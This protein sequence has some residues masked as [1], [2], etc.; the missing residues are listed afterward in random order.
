MIRKKKFRE[1][2]R[3]LGLTLRLN[4]KLD[5][6]N[7]IITTTNPSFSASFLIYLAKIET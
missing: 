2:Q 7:W 4:I 6:G 5:G 1:A 3:S